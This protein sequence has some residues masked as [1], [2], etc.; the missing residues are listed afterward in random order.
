MSFNDVLLDLMPSTLQIDPYTGVATDGYGEPTYTTSTSENYRCRVVT[1][2][3]QI[4][5]LF[6]ENNVSNTQI[7]VKSSATFSLFDKAT[8]GG[9]TLGPLLR[10]EHYPDE[11]GHHHS[12]LFFG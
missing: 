8:V 4:T 6:G 11:D 3:V 10:V 5:D 1:S 7:W 9:S 12:K 2:Q